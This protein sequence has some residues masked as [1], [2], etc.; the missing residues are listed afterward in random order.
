MA[1]ARFSMR[2]DPDV[3]EWLETEAKR[4]DRSV[5]YLAKQAILEM[6]QQ[7]EAK[8]QMYA[9]AIAKAEAGIFISEE[10]MTSW[11]ETLGTDD[12]LP[13]PTPDVFANRT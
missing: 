12:E 4:Q 13:A 9:D 7:S 8:Q 6:K 10:K 5:A 1:S 2:L 3:K 11:F